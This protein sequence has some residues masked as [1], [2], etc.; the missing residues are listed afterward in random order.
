MKFL[1]SP[2]PHSLLIR[3]QTEDTLFPTKL[4]QVFNKNGMFEEYY[5]KVE[6]K[7]FYDVHDS[8]TR[9]LDFKAFQ[10]KLPK[11]VTQVTKKGGQTVTEAIESFMTI[12]TDSIDTHGSAKIVFM[13]IVKDD[14][15]KKPRTIIDRCY[16]VCEVEI[17]KDTKWMDYNKLLEHL[18]DTEKAPITPQVP[19]KVA[20]IKSFYESYFTGGSYGE[21]DFVIINKSND[22]MIPTMALQNQCTQF[23]HYHCNNTKDEDLDCDINDDDELNKFRL[24]YND[25]K[26][27]ISNL[28]KRAPISPGGDAS[29]FKGERG[30]ITIGDSC[31]ISNDLEG[32]FE[33]FHANMD[34][35]TRI[36][37]NL[38]PERLFQQKLTFENE[39]SSGEIDYDE[40][41][42]S[43]PT[44][45]KVGSSLLSSFL[46]GGERATNEQPQSTRASPSKKKRS[47]TDKKDKKLESLRKENEELMDR[48]R[49]Y[50][51]TQK[52]LEI[53]MQ[54]IM[55]KNNEDHSRIPPPTPRNATA[56]GL[57]SIFSR[58]GEPPPPS[59]EPEINEIKPR[60][61]LP[62]GNMRS[63]SSIATS[64]SSKKRHKRATR[65]KGKGK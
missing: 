60:A 27:I 55:Q 14:K 34:N 19:G 53:N 48:L 10:E 2:Q 57:S 37:R 1:S 39:N 45:P 26:N 65:A 25:F 56:R 59:R 40:F 13:C 43:P 36:I 30:H 8:D 29:L 62:Y 42:K 58:S 17:S 24:S 51:K 50:D 15:D 21:H 20:S 6:N 12:I 28:K 63:S 7:Y 18:G 9:I 44:P 49:E 38:N 52:R 31:T 64:S 5:F 41:N 22:I 54:A 47:K 32:V 61:W 33:L 35:I 4:P 23:V 3:T 46:G 11:N 16:R